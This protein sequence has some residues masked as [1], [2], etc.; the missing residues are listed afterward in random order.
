M[1]FTLD[2]KGCSLI[3]IE[4]DLKKLNTT[5]EH[6]ESDFVAV[7]KRYGEQQLAFTKEHQ[8]IT[9]SITLLKETSAANRTG[10]PVGGDKMRLNQMNE[11]LNEID[12]A[13]EARAGDKEQH[14]EETLKSIGRFRET[15]A[16]KEAEA[17]ELR[18]I[19][20]S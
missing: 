18:A 15:I 20:A 11:R 12:K 19:I 9:R 16:A 17:V 5:L 7:E 2:L 8:E 10:G 6:A 4:K 1:Q 13:R 3:E 14:R